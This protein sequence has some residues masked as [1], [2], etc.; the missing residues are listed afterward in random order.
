MRTIH[1]FLA[2]R[3]PDTNQFFPSPG[4]RLTVLVC[5]DGTTASEI[6]H[7]FLRNGCSVLATPAWSSYFADERRFVTVRAG[8]GKWL[9]VLRKHRVGLVIGLDDAAILPHPVD[10]QLLHRAAGIPAIHL[11]LRSPLTTPAMSRLGFSLHDYL[12]FLRDAQTLN[13]LPD[14]DTAEALSRFLAIENTAA[15]PVGV[16][17]ELWTGETKPLTDRPW[18]AC[19]VEEPLDQPLDPSVASDTIQS[20]AERVAVA[21]LTKP[22]GPLV[23]AVEQVGGPG[24]QRGSTSRRPYELAAN[25][26]EEFERWRAVGRSV[27]ARCRAEVVSA[28]SRRLADGLRIE[29]LGERPPEIG[30]L[31]DY[32]ATAKLSFAL[33]SGLME[34]GNPSRPLQIA[35]AGGLLLAQGSRSIPN[36]FKLGEE[37]LAFQ[38][39]AELNEQI[40]RVLADAAQFQPMVTAA[41]RRVEVEHS[42]QLRAAQLLEVAQN[43]LKLKT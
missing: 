5:G 28:A 38:S 16:T 15:L 32:F 3:K 39:A 1:D 42:W 29:H 20:W 34:E 12:G 9:A 22:A 13:V 17:P 25:L 40:D 7:A 24:E 35:T 18:D 37:C 14:S 8:Y 33:S 30:R 21:K 36:L 11:W 23:D 27:A 2:A 4:S 41:R 43:R 19:L 6:A 10:R 31:R 26:P